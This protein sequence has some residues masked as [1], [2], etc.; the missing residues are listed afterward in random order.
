MVVTY[1][2][3][4]ADEIQQRTRQ[5]I[6]EAGLPLETV[7]AFGRAFFGTIH[8]FC[9]KLLATHGHRLG[10]PARLETIADD[11]DLWNEFVQQQTEIGHSLGEENRRLLLRLMQARQLM[12]LARNQDHIFIP[13]QS[14]GRCPECDFRK[15]EAAFESA[16]ATN[17]PK[18]KAQLREWLRR[19]RET[20]EFA[21]WPLCAT[22]ARDFTARWRE[23]FRPLREWASACASCV[24]VELQR[25]YREFRLARGAITYRDQVALAAELLRLPDVAKRIREKNYRVILDEAQDTDPQQFFVLLEITRPMEATAEWLQ[26]KRDDPRAGHF[27]MVGD[28]QQS[29]Y[30]DPADLNQYRELHR[31]LISTGAAEELRFSVTF[32]LDQAQ[33]DFVNDT[34]PKILNN[35]EGQVEFV[36]LSPRAEILPGQVIRFDLGDDIDASQTETRRA[37]IEAQ[38]LAKWIRD[39]GLQKLRARCWREVAILC[40]R[41]AWLRAIRDAL[42]EQQIPVEVQSESDRQAEHPAYAWLTA[43]LA[44]MVDPNASYEIVGVL[45]E[46]FGIS[47]DELA[48]FAQADCDKFQIERKTNGRGVVADRLNLLRQVRETLPHQPLFS[49]VREIVRMTQLRERLRT[50]PREEFGNSANEL[51]KL[52][53]AAAAAEARPRSVRPW[54]GRRWPT[55]P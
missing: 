23:A 2:N 50:L 7:E 9:V 24:A 48:R 31:T 52:L 20:D 40:P 10:L 35:A 1:T 11:D 26:T 27:C 14:L 12:D 33:L 18:A 19:W 13:P 3:R 25:D 43:V 28:F 15:V 51:E 54:P 37:Q 4:A 5:R 22:T 39:A 6:L 41:K 29:I 49:A 32:R 53:S 42:L 55:S 38:R 34:F 44:I 30:R 46:V 17:I 16:Q 21:P 36:E 45:R 8:A 47:D